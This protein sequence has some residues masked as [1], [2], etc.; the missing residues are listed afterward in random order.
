M[1]D[2][3]SIVL[4]VATARL[5]EVGEQHKGGQELQC[6]H[7]LNSLARHRLGW[8]DREDLK[9]RLKLEAVVVCLYAQVLLAK[10]DELLLVEAVGEFER[11]VCH[12]S[13]EKLED[14]V[15]RL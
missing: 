10:R 11:V 15:R 5:S 14:G 7:E 1:L 9:D 2:E 4:Q 3:L 8:L 12:E 6:I 13:F